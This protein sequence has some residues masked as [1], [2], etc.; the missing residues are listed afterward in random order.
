MKGSKNKVS[1]ATRPFK[2]SDENDRID[3][4]MGLNLGNPNKETGKNK[5]FMWPT[6]SADSKAS[7]Q[8]KKILAE[9]NESSGSNFSDTHSSKSLN[10]DSK[11]SPKTTPKPSHKNISPNL[12]AKVSPKKTPKSYNSRD[13]TPSPGPY[14]PLINYLSP[15]P[16]FL[17]YDPGRRKQI[18]MRLQM[19]AKDAD[20]DTDSCCG[21]DGSSSC[22]CG[23]ISDESG[24][25]LE[26]EDDEIDIESD[27]ESEEEV[28]WNIIRK[29]F[30]F[31]LWSIILLLGT[32]YICSMNS[33]THP[34]DF[35]L[36][37]NSSNGTAESVVEGLLV[38]N[39]AVLDKSIEESITKRETLTLEIE[40]RH[41]VESPEMVEQV[42]TDGII[43]DLSEEESGKIA[44]A[45]DQ[46]GNSAVLDKSIEESITKRETLTLEIEDRHHVE[47]P[48]MVEQ[49]KTDGIIEDLSEEESG[50]IAYASDHF[51][52]EK[53]TVKETEDVE[54][55]GE[56]GD[57]I[58]D[59][60][61]ETKEVSGQHEFLD[62]VETGEHIEDVETEDVEENGESGDMIEDELVETKEVSGQHEFLDTVETGEHIEDVEKV[63]GVN[64][65]N[66]SEDVIEEKLVKAREVYDQMVIV[67]EE[68]VQACILCDG[69]DHRETSIDAT[70]PLEKEMMDENEAWI[71]IQNEAIHEDM[72][73]ATILQLLFGALTCVTIVASLVLGWWRKAIA[74]KHS[75]RVDK[76]SSEP[77][78]NEKL[79]L[80]LPA[81]RED[82]H[83]LMNT[84]PLDNSAD[85]DIE[86]S[87]QRRAPSVELLSE[88][89]VG[90]ISSA[91]KSCGIT[92]TNNEVNSHS[93]FLEK[94]LGS[95]AYAVTVQDKKSFSEFTPVNSDSSK[96]LTA[97]KKLFKKELVNNSTAGLDGE[98]RNEVQT[99]STLRRSDRLRNRSVTSP[100]NR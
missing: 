60:L 91:R 85:K 70:Y 38:L 44:Y 81:E 19:N 62:T 65:G 52:E 73:Q 21:E 99:P 25:V 30:K 48:E 15:R 20:D 78:L 40:D 50:K 12:D 100:P 5:N 43:E 77:V 4:E 32:A 90:A 54:E 14:D 29:G 75:S 13:E 76:H 17:R 45:S 96:K 6:V 64:E 68:D 63:K 61:V 97:K 53:A 35:G 82:H 49:V 83:A 26:Q 71:E 88:L 16:Q 57:I 95:K 47:S 18:F 67:S 89:E 10:F 23:E 42:K 11:P 27:E 9:R 24:S 94:D 56:S 79:S 7:F 84:L 22:E 74:S 80:V 46:S 1:F 58:E 51:S 69:S 8:R 86:E 92:T 36:I 3:Q 66:E 41:H 28:G 59:E 98:G 87:Y 39:S 72:V 2:G 93:D 31:L 33:P 34:Q 37:Q 55:N